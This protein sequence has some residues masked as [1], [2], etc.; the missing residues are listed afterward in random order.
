MYKT[1]YSISIKVKGQEH[2]WDFAESIASTALNQIK[3]CRDVDVYM[4]IEG[5]P[6]GIIIP[7]HAIEYVVVTTTRTETED[8]VDDNCIVDGGDE[9]AET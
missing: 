6:Q 3:A 9:P 8:P 2:P 1:I 4:Q 7:Y 5:V